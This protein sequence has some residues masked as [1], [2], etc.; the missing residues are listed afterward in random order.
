M[1]AISGTVEAQTYAGTERFGGA[2]VY[3]IDEAT[4]TV[5]ETTSNSDGTFEVTGLDGSTQHTVIAVAEDGSRQFRSKTFPGVE[6]VYSLPNSAIH[7][8]KFSE[9]T[10]DVLEDSIGSATGTRNGPSW[11]S[12][13]WQGGYALDGDGSNDHADLT[14]LGSFGS[15]MDSG[16]AIAFTMQHTSSAQDKA[17]AGSYDGLKQF[18]FIQSYDTN[19]GGGVGSLGFGLRDDLGNKDRVA[20]NNSIFDDGTK[21]RVV[22]QRLSN[23]GASNLEIYDNTTNLP[24]SVDSDQGATNFIDFQSPFVTHARSNGGTTGRHMD[25]I[26]DDL[27]IYDSPLSSTE[28]QGDYNIQPWT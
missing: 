17:V 11:I 25:V 1:A 27:I 22:C 21:H 28:I 6:T 8:W 10:G 16:F 7:R 26:I 24:L 23:S 3:V 9:G 13:T 12:D 2:T 19:A 4:G 20:T 14:T 18:L 15:N 5:Y